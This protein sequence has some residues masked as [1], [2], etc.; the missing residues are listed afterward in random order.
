M[1]GSAQR[2]PCP[3]RNREPAGKPPRLRREGPGRAAG[4]KPPPRTGPGPRARPQRRSPAAPAGP[5]CRG[6][7]RHPTATPAASPLPW[8][9][10]PQPPAAGSWA[11]GRPEAARSASCRPGPRPAPRRAGGRAERSGTRRRRGGRSPGP[12]GVEARRRPAAA[13]PAVSSEGRGSRWNLS[14]TRYLLSRGFGGVSQARPLPQGRVLRRR[15]RATREPFCPPR[16]ALSSIPLKSRLRV[17]VSQRQ[18]PGGCSNGRQC[19]YPSPRPRRRRG[20]EAAAAQRGALGQGQLQ[21]RTPAV[22][23][24]TG[25]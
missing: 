5:R 8:R 13:G 18:V 2:Q 1:Q 23:D 22:P 17:G 12:G 15:R 4:D 7:P 11:R 24:K 21:V 9:G 14:G 16:G 25:L 10:R 6:R 20:E 3:S 19:W